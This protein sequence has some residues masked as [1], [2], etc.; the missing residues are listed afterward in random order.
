MLHAFGSGDANSD[1]L[2]LHHGVVS[3]WV[4]HD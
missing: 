3:L 1:D 4:A 2:Q